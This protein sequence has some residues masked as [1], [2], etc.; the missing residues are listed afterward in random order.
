MQS[1]NIMFDQNVKNKKKDADVLIT[2]A[3]GDVAMLDF[4]QKKRCMEAGIAAA[5]QAV[6]AIRE[7]LA[8]WRPPVATAKSG[9]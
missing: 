4:S 8:A 2:P 9:S 1:V 3:V 5:R 7:R 6:P